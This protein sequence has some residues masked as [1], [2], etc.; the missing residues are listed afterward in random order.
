MTNSPIEA[1]TAAGSTGTVKVPLTAQVKRLFGWIVPVNI[2]IYLI[3]GAVPGVLLP[4]QVQAIDEA[5]KAVNLAIITGVGAAAAIVASPLIGLL[6]DRTRSR[7]GRRSPWMLAGALVTGLS[8]VGMGFADGVAQLLIGWIVVQIALNLMISPL[9]AL[10]PDRVPAAVRGVFSTLAGLG[11]I[12]GNLGGNVL[13]SAFAKNIQGAYL[14]IPGLVIVVVA[15]FVVLSPDTSSRDQ[16]NEPFSLRIFLKTFWVSPR[17]HP[18]FAWGF[19]ARI[20][21]FAG[22]YLIIGY[23]LYVLQDYIG[24]GD[25]AV[26]AVP[27]LSLV[28]VVFILIALAIS[29]PLSDRI[30]RRRPIVIAASLIMAVGMVVPLLMPTLLGMIFFIAISG[31]GFGAYLSVDQALM[32]EVLPSEQ[33]FAKD[34]GVLNIAVTLPQTIGPFL[35]GALVVLFGYA[36]LFPVGV[37][38]AIIGAIC[39]V[40]IR[41]V[42]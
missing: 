22:Y 2:V 42:R 24:L 10:L 19:A 6:S 41:S 9:T 33:S 39:I 36:S 37:V 34:L 28:S 3:V 40:P 5:S 26:E 21:L 8:L 15:L 16:V 7:F 29:G 23:Q 30:G 14:I 13:G 32:S 12:L 11:L 31:F 17:K 38:L 20:T 18:D 27:L 35:G 25:K 1:T 4:L